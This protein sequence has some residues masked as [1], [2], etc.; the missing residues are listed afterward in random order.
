MSGETPLLSIA[1][2]TFNRAKYLDRLLRTLLE[3]M[4]IGPRVELLVSDNAS[5][6]ETAAVVAAY[7]NRGMEIRYIRNESNIGTDRNILQLFAQASGKY[8]WIFSDDDLIAPGTLER[9]LG[10]LSLNQYDMI[11]ISAYFFKGDYT[12]HRR[13][14]PTPDLDCARAED[15]ALHVH[16]LFTF[17]SGIIINKE[18][19]S[20]VPHPPF[21]SL[22]DTNL[23]QLGPIFTA[24]NHQRK[25]LLI[26]DPL[27]A[28]TGN[29]TVGYAIYD[30]FGTS[31]AK[32][33]CEWIERKS[34]QKA[35]I[36]GTIQRFFPSWILM[37]RKSLAS[38][39]P[40]DPH[41]VLRRCYGDHFRYWV[42][43]YPIY[44]LPLPLAAAWLLMVR[45]FNKLD[46]LF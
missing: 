42:F 37:S 30:V 46:A 33:T 12:H 45:V 38:S 35:I 15:L 22:F 18:L 7:Q 3:Q 13:F 34:V 39:V 40:E 16:V 10:A 21:E 9:V 27:I 29:G 4:P 14:T 24:L 20:S 28:A 26:R 17:I 44:A 6:D 2:P 43:D 8:V 25:S 32:I 19:I 36:N 41:L 31:L 23:A 11:C 1:I 5:P